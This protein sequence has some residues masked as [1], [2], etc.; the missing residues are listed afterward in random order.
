[1]SSNRGGQEGGTSGQPVPGTS[2]EAAMEIEELISEDELCNLV[3]AAKRF[4]VIADLWKML[5]TAPNG[6]SYNLQCEKCQ[7]VHRGAKIDRIVKH[8]VKCHNNTGKAEQLGK[9]YDE[10]LGCS[11]ILPQ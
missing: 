5:G 11:W 6:R 7:D 3:G 10:W 2:Q 1:M 4:P 8:S 9:E